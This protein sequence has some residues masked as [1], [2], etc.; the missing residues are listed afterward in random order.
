MRTEKRM[1]AEEGRKRGERPAG[2]AWEQRESELEWWGNPQLK[3]L[4]VAGG[5]VSHC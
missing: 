2:N 1:D 3:H 4:E 5:D